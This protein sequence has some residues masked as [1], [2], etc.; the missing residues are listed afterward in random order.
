MPRALLADK[1]GAEFLADCVDTRKRSPEAIR[2]YGVVGRLDRVLIEP[3]WIRD[4]DRHRPDSGLDAQRRKRCLELA[5]KVSHAARCQ[6]N[7]SC[8]AAAGG[9]PQYVVDEVEL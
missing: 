6:G 9:E 2:E 8:F 3:D 4:F 5:V 7:R 1:P